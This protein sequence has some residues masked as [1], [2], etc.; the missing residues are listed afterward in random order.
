MTALFDRADNVIST[1]N[2]KIEEKH[3]I[4]AALQQNGYPKEFIQRRLKKH[5]RSKEQPRD[6][7]EEEL[8]QTKR[9]NPPYIELVSEQL[10][11]ALNKYSIKAIF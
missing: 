8:K 3:H 7:P 10:K 1:E 11:W 2:D 5:N 6:C 9:I 4:L